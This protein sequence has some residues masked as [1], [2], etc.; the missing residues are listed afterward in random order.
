MPGSSTTPGACADPA[1][2]PGGH[3]AGAEA[4]RA[5]QGA[6]DDDGADLGVELLR[7][8][9]G[10][11]QDRARRVLVAA[12]GRQELDERVRRLLTGGEH[13]QASASITSVAL[14]TPREPRVRAIS[15][16]V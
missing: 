8:Q 9:L 16:Y 4:H 11:A 15:P 2:L 6:A 13:R 1:Q 3:G 14:W 12:D 10:R 5:A 7:R